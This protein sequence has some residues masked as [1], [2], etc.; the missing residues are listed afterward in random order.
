[1]EYGVPIYLVINASE[2]TDPLEQVVKKA[3][4]EA[5]EYNSTLYLT[6]NSGKPGQPPP[7][8]GDD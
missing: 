4:K 7:P 6:I 2:M 3:I 1:M 5:N 8:P